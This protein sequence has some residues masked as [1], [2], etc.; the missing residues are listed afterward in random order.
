MLTEQIEYGHKIKEEMKVTQ[1]EIKQNIQG[2]NSDWKETGTQ[3]KDLNQ[4][5]EENIQQEQNE[6]TRTQKNEERVRN[7]WDHFKCSNIWI[8]G[9]PE[10]EEEEQEIENWFEQKWRKTPRNSQRN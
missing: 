4:K 6:K 5:E 1:S 8:I 10:G 2:T 3:I 7:L 9:V